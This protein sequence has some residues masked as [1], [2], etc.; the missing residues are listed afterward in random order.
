MPITNVLLEIKRISVQNHLSEPFIVGGL[1]RDKVLGLS[2]N[3]EDVD[4]TTG[5]SSV[6]KLVDFC[7]NQFQSSPMTFEDGHKQ[8]IIENIKYDFSSN[9]HS[10]DVNYFLTQK[11]GIKDPSQMQLELFSRDF[12]CNTLIIPMN[13]RNTFDDNLLIQFHIFLLMYLKH[14]PNYLI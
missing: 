6:N 8:L 1:P 12:T 9:F 7:A 11:A 3:I 5:D 10:P 2:R 14:S 13:L 4:I